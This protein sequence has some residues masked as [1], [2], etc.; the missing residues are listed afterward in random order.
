M[1]MFQQSL[2]STKGFL[3]KQRRW[4]FPGAL[5]LI[6]VG[7]G[8]IWLGLQQTS[9]VI[10]AGDPIQVRTAAWRVSGVLR[11][12]GVSVGE[13]D[14][15][16]PEGD[17]WFWAPAVITVEPAREVLIRTPADEVRLRTAERIPANLIAAIGVDL[18]PGDRV[19]VNGG[20]V[21]PQQPLEGEGF[22][23]LQFQ[24]A[25]AVHLVIDGVESR[26]FS[27]ESTLG[28]ALEAAQ[29]FIA[30]QDW[31]S[32]DLMT[33]L[34]ETLNVVIR[35][36]RLVRISAGGAE[37]TGLTAAETVSEAL[38]D[39]GF[40]LQN[41]DQSLPAEDEP[42]PVT[43]EIEIVRVEEKITILKDEVP[44]QNE[45]VE[46]PNTF[47]DEISV[48]TPGQVG[49][50]ASRERVRY[51]AGEEVWRDEPQSWQASEAADGVLGYGSRVEVRTEV[52]DG[53]EIEFWRKISVYA[54]SFSPCRLGLGEG[55]CNDRTASGL[56][57]QKGIVSVTR[58]WYNMMR[59][60]PVFVQG[61]GRGVIADIGGGGLYFSH[62]WIDLG[63]SDN[64]YQ[65]WSRWTTLY[66][67]TP[68]PA[69]YPA[70]L[71]WP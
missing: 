58:N 46:D 44:Y 17:L 61:Y 11:A 7:L 24:P 3:I 45:Y 59:L 54:T 4:L 35:R 51:A 48:V 68:V 31:I 69:W 23:L 50:Y 9:T 29:V 39:L 62:F 22:V 56:P 66:F 19:L 53:Q 34:D 25:V 64:D 55:V 2:C 37:L 30:P 41:L 1:H 15:L 14:R 63:F 49:I 42:V 33:P 57:L 26:F 6:L 52:V 12:A 40:G 60:Q 65:Q 8:L 18:F 47:L 10:V 36:A 27:Q 70:V 28:A 13:D 43:G 71:P 38:H 67:L 5:L 16:T 21:D 32:E 20:V